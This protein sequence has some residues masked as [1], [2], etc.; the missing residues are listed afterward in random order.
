MWESADKDLSKLRV[1]LVA[2]GE[3]R[4]SQLLQ[5][6]E[7]V[8]FQED[9]SVCACLWWHRW[10]NLV[11]I[12][13][14]EQIS[15]FYERVVLRAINFKFFSCK[16]P[17]LRCRR[18]YVGLLVLLFEDWARLCC[19]FTRVLVFWLCCA[20]RFFNC[21]FF[22]RVI[23]L[24]FRLGFLTLRWL[25]FR[26]LAVR[27][28]ATLLRTTLLAIQVNATLILRACLIC[29]RLTGLLDIFKYAFEHLLSRIRI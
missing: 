14:H 18:I 6:V 23:L 1:N 21:I 4:L 17:F 24:R 16:R 7:S 8:S 3:R 2:T 10:V 13:F 28:E 25:Y 9:L 29:L 12:G 11:L 5:S 26:K 22:C 15:L 27:Q 20:F 19:F